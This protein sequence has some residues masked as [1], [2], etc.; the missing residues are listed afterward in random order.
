V[1]F[2]TLTMLRQLLA[3]VPAQAVA[4][5]MAGLLGQPAPAPATETAAA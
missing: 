1:Y 3:G 4:G 2:D 5:L